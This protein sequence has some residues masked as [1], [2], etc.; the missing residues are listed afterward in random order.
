MHFLRPGGIDVA[1][2]AQGKHDM[3]WVRSNIRAGSWCAL[4]AL[5]IQFALSFGHVHRGEFPQ[6]LIASR[7]AIATSAALPGSEVSSALAK[8]IGLAEDYCAICAVMVL[9]N[10]VR[11]AV[12]P[13]FPRP[14]GS[15]AARFWMAAE[16]LAAT[17]LHR[18]FQARA[19]PLV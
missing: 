15:I 18:L 16:V 10:S 2:G 5:V 13:A 8:P 17:S 19:P 1:G 14:A 11:P 12:A 3:G 6:G 4:F 9:A 7:S